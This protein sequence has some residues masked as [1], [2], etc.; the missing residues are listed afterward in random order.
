V[1]STL[2]VYGFS[3]E[4]ELEAS[5]SDPARFCA[6]GV[7]DHLAPDVERTLLAERQRGLLGVRVP[8]L[9]DP[10]ARTSGMFDRLLETCNALGLVVMLPS[11][12]EA[13]AEFLPKYPQIFFFLNHMGT[14]LAPPIVGYGDPRPFARLDDVLALANLENVGLKLT[15]VPA[16]STEAFPFR[17]VWEPIRKS[18]AAFGAD[19]LAWGSDYT[20]TSGLHSYW[21]AANYLQEVDGLS[22]DDL[23]AIYAGTIVNRL[24]W[25]RGPGDVA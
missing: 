16:L 1:L 7:V 18:V 14:G 21:E 24:G 15:G 13:L 10:E 3:N 9:R 17:D 19:R 8:G 25:S 20:R 4:M 2:G 12:N 23:E 22:A 6:V 5:T 11:Y